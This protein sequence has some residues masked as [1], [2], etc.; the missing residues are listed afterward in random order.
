M[1]ACLQQ[2]LLL[3]LLV[4]DVDD[5]NN[6]GRGCEIFSTRD[7]VELSTGQGALFL[8]CPYESAPKMAVFGVVS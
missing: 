8:G 3:L 4:D 2:L 1:V 6:G 7:L 5:V